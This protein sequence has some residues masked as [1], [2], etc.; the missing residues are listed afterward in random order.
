ML[1]IRQG[2]RMA[3]C[4][5]AAM[6]ATCSAGIGVGTAAEICAEAFSTGKREKIAPSSETEAHSVANASKTMAKPV[7]GKRILAETE[8]SKST[9]AANAKMK[10]VSAPNMFFV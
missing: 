4:R 8:L 7:I 2:S 9:A 6:A 10:F 3:V 1:A 5:A